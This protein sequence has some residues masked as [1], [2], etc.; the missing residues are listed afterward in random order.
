MDMGGPE[1]VPATTASDVTT[2]N[3]ALGTS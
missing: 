3:P 1:P 2:P